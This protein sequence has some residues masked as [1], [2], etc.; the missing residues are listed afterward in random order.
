MLTFDAIIKSKNQ[1]GDIA[2]VPNCGTNR[3]TFQWNGSRVQVYVDATYIG[4]IVVN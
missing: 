4:N 1:F 3:M 2:N